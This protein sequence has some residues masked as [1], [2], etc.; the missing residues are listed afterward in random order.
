MVSVDGLKEVFFFGAIALSVSFVIPVNVVPGVPPW[1]PVVLVVKV[2]D[3]GVV[4][5]SR[6]HRVRGLDQE[7]VSASLLF[8]V[9]FFSVGSFLFVCLVV[10]RSSRNNQILNQYDERE[11]KKL[12]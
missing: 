8:V 5:K 10:R 1:F 12:S 6:C 9:L 3:V 2:V 4:N 11:Q 7:R